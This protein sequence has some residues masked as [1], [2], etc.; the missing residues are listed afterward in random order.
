MSYSL[1]NQQ[2]MK[3]TPLKVRN[4]KFSSASNPKF[5]SFN[6]L[7]SGKKLYQMIRV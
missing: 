7:S 4:L 3:N 5:F 2:R 1:K 6:F